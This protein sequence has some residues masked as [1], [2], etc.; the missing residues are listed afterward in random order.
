MMVA[1]NMSGRD[2]T[3]TALVQP[4]PYNGIPSMLPPTYVAPQLSRRTKLI[5]GGAGLALLAAITTVA[6]IK[7]SSSTASSAP[8]PK[9]GSSARPQIAPI[10][11][12]KPELARTDPKVEAKKVEPKVTPKVEAAIPATPE[13]KVDAKQPAPEPEPK[14]EPKVEPKAEPKVEAR[15]VEP[16]R[17]VKKEPKLEPKREVKKEKRV[18]ATD[19]ADVRDKADSLYRSKRFNDAASALRSAAGSFG[20]GDAKDLKSLAAVYEQLGKAYNIGMASSTSPDAAFKQLQVALNMENSAGGAFK[21]EIRAKLSSVAPR[22]ALSFVSNKD[23]ASAAAAVRL[24]EQK[25]ATSSTKLVRAQLESRAKE[26]YE[27]AAKELD[28]N[29][30]EAKAKLKQI[31]GLVE[32]KSPWYQKA[33]KLLSGL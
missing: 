32:S 29:P 2:P 30:G 5:L 1:S 26:L 19:T 8:P 11:E 4:T 3:S 33:E 9:T 10:S 27:Q 24:A 16:K 7:S 6:I 14:P 21:D 15:K 20:D 28:A 25:G 18:A 12:A 17:E 23:Y 13:P 22:A 31:K